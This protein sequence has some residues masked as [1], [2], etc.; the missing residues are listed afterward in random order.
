MELPL[1]A[2]RRC[3]AEI[4]EECSTV[5]ISPQNITWDGSWITENTGRVLIRAGEFHLILT[6]AGRML[7]YYVTKFGN[8]Q[9]RAF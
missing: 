9:P 5:L 4:Y 2:Y 1:N 7:V 6:F 8:A 3:A